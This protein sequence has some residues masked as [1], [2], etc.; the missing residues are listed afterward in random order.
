LQQ[1]AHYYSRYHVLARDDLLGLKKLAEVCT[2]LEE[3]GVE[4][5][6]C[7]QAGER[8]IHNSQFARSAG[9][10]H[11]RPAH[12]GGVAGRRKDVA[13]GVVKCG[14]QLQEECIRRE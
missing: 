2:A 10:P 4:D 6:N 13:R 14:G 12:R 11:R 3:A 9:G 7:C 8:V 1:A 5:E